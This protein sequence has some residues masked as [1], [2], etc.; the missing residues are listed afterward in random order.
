MLQARERYEY[1]NNNEIP[2]EKI[3]FAIKKGWNS[4]LLAPE[5]RNAVA[6][7]CLISYLLEKNIKSFK[8]TLHCILRIFLL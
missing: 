7:R 3:H 5:V 4:K 1:V 2:K 8:S 6:L